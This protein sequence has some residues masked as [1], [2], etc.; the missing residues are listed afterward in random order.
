MFFNL[1]RSFVIPQVLS[2]QQLVRQVLYTIFILPCFTCAERK[3]CST[4]AKSQ[5][6]MKMVEVSLKSEVDKFD[7]VKL[8][9]IPIDLAKLLHLVKIDVLKKMCLTN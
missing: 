1:I 5:N 2:L 9:S 8:A 7:I 4:L 6:I 3:N